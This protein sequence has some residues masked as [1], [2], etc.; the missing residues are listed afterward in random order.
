MQAREGSCK[1]QFTCATRRGGHLDAQIFRNTVEFR[2]EVE[3]TFRRF[4]VFFTLWYRFT[5]H[6]T[7]DLYF[8]MTLSSA[9]GSARVAVI[10]VHSPVAS[11]IAT[12]V[13]G[14]GQ[15]LQKQ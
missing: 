14:E 4:A 10:W 12:L 3:L 11:L 9:F 6:A 8:A 2:N 5:F 15:R 7:T 1:N 13:S